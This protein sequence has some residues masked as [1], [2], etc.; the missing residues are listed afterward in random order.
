MVIFV[1]MFGCVLVLRG[2]ATT[3]MP[4][5]ETKAQVNPAVA[6][7]Y[8]FFAD[9]LAGGPDFNLIEVGASVVHFASSES[10]CAGVK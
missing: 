5:D 2:I 3:Y 9:V 8:A 4:A 10:W 1:E 7:L 6:G